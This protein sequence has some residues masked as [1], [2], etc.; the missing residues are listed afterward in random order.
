ML[1]T[2]FTVV[3]S[4]LFLSITTFAIGSGS[5][6]GVNPVSVTVVFPSTVTIVCVTHF[7]NARSNSFT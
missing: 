2:N 3:L 5:S 7:N 1:Y 4:S 6:Y